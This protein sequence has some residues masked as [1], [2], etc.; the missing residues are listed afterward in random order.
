MKAARSNPRAVGQSLQSYAIMPVQRVPR[1]LLLLRELLKNTLDDHMDKPALEVAVE[2]VEDAVKH[3]NAAIQVPAPFGAPV[4]GC[5][6]TCAGTRSVTQ[7]REAAQQLRVLQRQFL[8]SV[9]L[10]QRGRKLLKVNV[11]SKLVCPCLCPCTC[12]CVERFQ[13]SLVRER[14]CVDAAG[15]SADESVPAHRQEVLLSLV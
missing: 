15:G 8:G 1:Y 13:S 12:V 11:P 10:L 5:V 2:H 6:L 14:V 4:R 3:M 9:D 7:L